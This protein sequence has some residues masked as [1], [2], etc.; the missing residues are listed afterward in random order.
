MTEHS[1]DRLDIYAVLQCYGCE[2]MAEIMDP[3]LRDTCP[4]KDT[5]ERI[6]HTVRRDGTAIGRREYILVF[7]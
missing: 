1:T 3:D 4:F 6:V 7:R 5:L 2:G